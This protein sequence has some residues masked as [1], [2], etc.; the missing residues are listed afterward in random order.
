MLRIILLSCLL[1]L[2]TNTYAALTSSPIYA[3]CATGF[4]RADISSCRRIPGPTSPFDMAYLTCYP[5]QISSKARS[6]TISLDIAVV[7]NGSVNTHTITV[8]NTDSPGCPGN[9]IV[10]RLAI[11]ETVLAS[12]VLLGQIAAEYTL[13]IPATSSGT[14]YLM[15]GNCPQCA[16]SY[17]V[18]GYTDR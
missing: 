15:F 4:E 2:S 3:P 14:V 9:T 10:S 5:I 12:G 6:M 7:G 16:A 17:Y 18:T 13:P 11:R 8:F 1:V